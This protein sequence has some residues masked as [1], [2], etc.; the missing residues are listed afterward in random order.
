MVINR[1]TSTL[2]IAATGAIVW[3]FWAAV[4][5][6]VDPREFP[7]L[8]DVPAFRNCS[9]LEGIGP[10][11]TLR[12]VGPHDNLETGVTWV[13]GEWPGT[14]FQKFAEANRLDLDL[15]D[16]AKMNEVSEHLP[17]DFKRG[18]IFKPDDFTA[19]G[20]ICNGKHRLFGTHSS[21]TGRFL[22]QIQR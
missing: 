10:V 17:A 11:R 14:G 19:I 8:S 3:L 2:G 4:R 20:P 22:F 15:F 18:L 12:Y 21:E 7:R 13:T 5:T 9:D 16:G 6:R 1:T